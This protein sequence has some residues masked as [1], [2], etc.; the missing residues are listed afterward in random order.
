MDNDFLIRSSQYFQNTPAQQEAYRYIWQQ[1][2]DTQ[3][4]TAKNL[5]R[6]KINKEQLLKIDKDI[7]K[8]NVDRYCQLLNQQ[9]ID[10]N[11]STLATAHFIAQIL[12]E[13]D[14]L[15][16]TEEYHDGSDYEGS[17]VLGNT[18]TGDGKRYKGRG[19]IQLTGRWNYNACG[20]ALKVDLINNPQQLA[21]YPYALLSAFWYWDFRGCQQYA[22]KDDVEGLTKVINGGFNGLADRIALLRSTKKVLGI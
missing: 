8:T 16:R 12:H 4:T 1:L 2:S 11:F 13:S 7:N 14:R 5:W 17:T 3:Q 18:Q 15:H 9:L 10:R 22:D 6:Q 21:T 19:L 20:Q